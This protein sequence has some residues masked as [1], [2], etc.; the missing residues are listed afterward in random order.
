M[1]QDPSKPTPPIIIPRLPSKKGI[2]NAEGEDVNMKTFV[3]GLAIA[4]LI[5]SLAWVTLNRTHISVAQAGL[6]QGDVRLGPHHG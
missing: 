6:W 5:A 4:A 3:T 1:G 2:R